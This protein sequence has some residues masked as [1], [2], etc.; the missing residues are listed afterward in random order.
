MHNATNGARAAG[1]NAPNATATDVHEQHA[2]ATKASPSYTP[3]A[4]KAQNA[5]A[6]A[7]APKPSWLSTALPSIYAA[8]S[9]IWQQ[10]KVA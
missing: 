7:G 4:P 2:T 10:P 3:P 8:A 9:S 5:T 6:T 1:H